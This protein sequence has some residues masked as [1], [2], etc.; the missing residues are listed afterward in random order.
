MKKVI[1]RM[2]RAS[3]FYIVPVLLCIFGTTLGGEL[4]INDKVVEWHIAASIY[5]LV[6]MAIEGILIVAMLT[7]AAVTGKLD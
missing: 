6:G 5:F 2:A 7:I 1:D 3:Y 4:S